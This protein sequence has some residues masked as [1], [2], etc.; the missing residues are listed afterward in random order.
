LSGCGNNV[1]KENFNKIKDGMSEK[2][3]IAILGSP[4][5][6]Q[7][8]VG[9]K[10]ST[11]KDGDKFIAITFLNDKVVARI[12]SDGK[13]MPEFGKD[14][15]ANN[16]G[17][18]F[19]G[20]KVP[21]DLNPNLEKKPVQDF[22]PQSNVSETK[23]SQLTTGMAEI[24]LTNVLGPPTRTVMNPNTGLGRLVAKTLVWQQGANSI[25]ADMNA[26]GLMLRARGTFNGQ[27]RQLG[28]GKPNL[29]NLPNKGGISKGVYDQIQ[30]GW[31]E[32]QVIGL[33][34][35]PTQRFGNRLMWQAGRSSITVEFFNGVVSGKTG[36][37]L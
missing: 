35:Q 8:G 23:F 30:F 17:N 12:W 33:L 3:V 32:A 16:K 14:T 10:V 22:Q 25:E 11:W 15:L 2:D 36:R 6:S 26:F 19:E 4:T 5:E 7:S 31:T 34:G 21:K 27:V 28:G 24:A 13:S 29:G 1:T 37:N 9:G 20:N 18:P